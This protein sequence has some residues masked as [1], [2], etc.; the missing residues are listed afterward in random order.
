M[1]L[2]LV[3]LLVTHVSSSIAQLN[4]AT[5][6]LV[7]TAARDIQAETAAVAH[8]NSAADQQQH[9]GGSTYSALCVVAKDENRYIAEWVQY[10][11]CLGE[12]V[13]AQLANASCR[14]RD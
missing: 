5:P 4:T 14:G 6:A 1:R 2:L 3:L 13:A 11:K 10:H 9:S 8:A 12:C 7:T